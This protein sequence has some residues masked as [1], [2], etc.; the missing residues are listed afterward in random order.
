MTSLNG[1]IQE[2][3]R[4]LGVGGA[5]RRWRDGNRGHGHEAPGDVHRQAAQLSGTVDGF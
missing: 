5:S 1:T 2:L 4:V 3:Q